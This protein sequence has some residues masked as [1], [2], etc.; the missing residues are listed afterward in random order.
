MCHVRR[1]SGWAPLSQH[2]T[3]KGDAHIPFPNFLRGLHRK[4]VRVIFLPANTPPGWSWRIRFIIEWR[5]YG[6]AHAPFPNF[7][8]GLHRKIVQ[9]IFLPANTPPGWSWRIW[10]I[11]EWREHLYTCHPF[12]PCHPSLLERS[13]HFPSFLTPGR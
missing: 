6:D 5:E 10:F 1:Q 13:S 12:S 3:A 7:L 4:I 11:I 9:V 8:R 2:K